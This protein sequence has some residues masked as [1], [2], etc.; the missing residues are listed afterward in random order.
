MAAEKPMTKV[1][2]YGAAK[3]AIDNFTKWLGVHFAEHGLRVNAIAPGFFLTN[4]NRALLTNPDGSLT[5]R[6]H[7]IINHTPMRRFGEARDLFGTISWLCD[8]DVSGFVTGSIIAVDGG[9]QSY[10][11]V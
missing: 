11:G 6:S 8:E 9:F 5:E 1:V 2:G 4:Q 3:A 10:S 7:K